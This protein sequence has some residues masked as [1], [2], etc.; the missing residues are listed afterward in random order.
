MLGCWRC[1]LELDDGCSRWNPDPGRDGLRRLVSVTVRQDAVTRA[2]AHLLMAAVGAAVTLVAGLG[3]PDFGPVAVISA[4][5]WLLGPANTLLI[6]P[7]SGPGPRWP[8]GPWHRPCR[9]SR[10]PELLV[11]CKK[12]V[13]RNVGQPQLRDLVGVLTREGADAVLMDS[14]TSFTH[15]ALSWLATSEPTLPARV[16]L[17]DA[18]TCE[19]LASSPEDGPLPTPVCLLPEGC[20][21][22]GGWLVRRQSWRGWLIGRTNYR[23]HG[24]RYTHPLGVDSENATARPLNSRSQR[25][26]R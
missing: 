15:E 24:C 3:G 26:A 19:L 17:W 23:Q 8:I 21:A 13:M 2:L 16:R 5:I 14:T 1:S 7:L 10:Q 6:K 9:H 4:W 20:P 25:H 12:L 18:Y 11:Q 22:C